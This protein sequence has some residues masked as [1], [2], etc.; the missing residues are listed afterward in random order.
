MRDLFGNV[1]NND[2]PISEIEVSLY[3][4]LPT[5][6][7]LTQEE[8]YGD[9]G[10]HAYT[11]PVNYSCTYHRTYVE[12]LSRRLQEE[13]SEVNEQDLP[14]LTFLFQHYEFFEKTLTEV[15]AK[16]QSRDEAEVAALRLAYSYMDYI[17]EGTL[18][19]ILIEKDDSGNNVL[20]FGTA[21]QWMD[22]CDSLL[23]LYEGKPDKYIRHMLALTS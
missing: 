15:I 20:E 11:I 13:N 18:P 16:K 2:S 4:D 1:L 6:T 14:R 8:A 22:L 5:D 23:P 12:Q 17:I 21:Q 10:R 7:N 9:L 3:A 19:D